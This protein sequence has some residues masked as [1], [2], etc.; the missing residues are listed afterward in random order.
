MPKRRVTEPHTHTYSVTMCD[1]T[2][3]IKNFQRMKR[4]EFLKVKKFILIYQFIPDEKV[5]STFQNKKF[6]YR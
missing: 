2:S 4:T 1:T 6:P 3:I 5:I